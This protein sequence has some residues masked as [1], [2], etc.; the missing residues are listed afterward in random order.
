MGSHGSGRATWIIRQF[1]PL[2]PLSAEDA[3][4]DA[5]L[6]TKPQSIAAGEVLLIVAARAPLP[7][8]ERDALADF[9]TAT[10]SADGDAGAEA[11][12]F[13]ALSDAVGA[14]RAEELRETL[15]PYNLKEGPPTGFTRAT[16]TP[17]VAFV[18]LPAADDTETKTH[19]WSK[20]ASAS[21][22]PERFVLLGYQGQTEVL[23]EL[24]QPVQTPL[25]V[26]VDPRTDAES[27][28]QFDADGNLTLGDELRWMVDFDE[29]VKRGMGFRVTLT[30]QQARGFD[31]LF[32][33]GV[34]LSTDAARGATD[35][36]G[37]VPQSSFRQIRIHAAAAGLAHQ[38]HR[39]ER[40]GVLAHGRCRR[41]LRFRLQGQGALRGNRRLARQ[42]R[43]S[44]ARRGAGPRH[45]LAETDPE[46]RRGR[47]IRSARDEHGAVARDAGLFHGHDAEARVR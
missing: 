47:S 24:G 39:R 8:A 12:A 4:G 1:R 31:R 15:R 29:A 17:R 26:S 20:A 16:A 14:A 13:D 28:F 9:W 21:L 40:L 44:M 3:E 5:T 18:F 45:R 27:Q 7:D 33:L 36:R 43:R 2:N 10:W 19:S 35:L 30:P 34:R 37:S 6:E 38:Q 11:D 41:E 42:A 25:H 22:L 32:V 46:R 23:N